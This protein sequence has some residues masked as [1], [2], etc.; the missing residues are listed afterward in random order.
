MRG[1][2]Y[3]FGFLLAALLVGCTQSTLYNQIADES[4]GSVFRQYKELSSDDVTC[5]VMDNNHQLWIG[6]SYGLN[7]YDGNVFTQFYT[8]SSDSL[9]IPNNQV[10]TLFK[11]SRGRIWIGTANGLALYVGYGRFKQFHFNRDNTIF[12]VTQIIETSDGRLFASSDYLIYQ[13]VPEAGFMRPVEPIQASKEMIR[14]CADQKGG[15]WVNKPLSSYYYDKQYRLVDSIVQ[16]TRFSNI[17]RLYRDV[18]NNE[19][20]LSQGRVLSCVDLETRKVKFSTETE[21]PI[22]P[23]L[24]YKDAN[25]LY[26]KSD[27]HGLYSFQC[28]THRL[29]FIDDDQVPTIKHNIL[30]S[31]LYKDDDQNLWIGYKNGGYQAISSACSD[32]ILLNKQPLFR[33]TAGHHI[34]TLA[35]DDHLIWGSTESNIFCYDLRDKTFELFPQEDVLIDTPYYRQTLKKILPLSGLLWLLTDVRAILVQKQGKSL[36]VL[37]VYRRGSMNDICSDGTD[38]Y[39][40]SHDG[41]NVDYIYYLHQD[42]LVDS[43]R[44][45][46]PS[47]DNQS[48]LF[49]LGGDELLLYMVGLKFA[50]LNTATKQMRNL[51]VKGVSVNPEMIPTCLVREGNSVWLGTKSHGLFR[52]DLAANALEAVPELEG[53]Q[54]MSLIQDKKGTLWMG[55]RSGVAIYRPQTKEATI[56]YTTA[57][58]NPQFNNFSQGCICQ[59]NGTI[60][61]GGFMGC[62][63]LPEAV[64]SHVIRSRLKIND[65]FIRSKDNRQIVY[66]KADS[67]S[68]Q[69]RY[70]QN[71]LDISFSGSIFDKSTAY[72]YR[73]RL[74]NFDNNWNTAHQETMAG[75]SNLPAGR[76][77]FRVQV[78]QI[79]GNTVIE[80]ASISI[81]I[82]KAPWL[83]APAMLAYLALLLGLIFYIN[84]L[85]LRLHAN[86]LALEMARKDKEREEKVNQMNMS[87][88]ANISHEFRNPLTIIAGP[89]AALNSDTGLPRQAHQKIRIV[90]QS[91]NRMLRLI[92]Q[93]LD[94]NQLETDALK[95]K[96]AEY[97]ICHEISQ[98]VDPFRES[99]NQRRVSFCCEGLDQPCYTWL[100]QDKL[101]KILS[102][103]YT[104]ALKHTPD[105]G[106]IRLTFSETTADEARSLFDESLP[107]PDY[108]KVELFN[109]GKQIPGDKLENVFKR[110][111]Q[112][113]DTLENHTYGWG[114]GIGLYYVKRLVTLH[115]GAISVRNVPGEGVV[116]CFVL[117]KGEAPYA[118]FER[119]TQKSPSILLLPEEKADLPDMPAVVKNRQDVNEMLQKPRLLIVDDDIQIGQYLHLLFE[120]RFVIVNKY[121]AESA[122]AEISQIDPDIIISDVIMNEMSGYEFCHL[123][124][125]DVL[126]SHIPFILLTA[127]SNVD[128][129]VEGLEQGA[130]AYVTKPFDPRYLQALVSSLLKNV[131]RIR[132]QLNTL[133]ETGHLSN[134]LSQQDRRFMDD[135]YHSMEKHITDL[136]L[137]IPTICEEMAMSRTKLNY[138]LKGLTGTT[139]GNFFKKYKLN[140]AASLLKEGKLNISEIALNTG[141]GTVAYFSSSFKK[142]FGIS[143]SKYK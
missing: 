2:G 16:P 19:M 131:E 4:R 60:F 35:K 135:L 101:D 123:L 56:K 94:F 99:A 124:K 62:A 111:Y 7:L 86:K 1:F 59:V 20:W 74:D 41:K 119:L 110:Y 112:V 21:M 92:D 122:L 49:H 136:D 51:D 48:R 33:Q 138:K 104:N 134:D 37:R 50:V 139:P 58:L 118:G 67:N 22:L 103:L 120:N 116:F 85:Y 77:R 132:E 117:P 63:A 29:Q 72:S 125:S 10:T 43:V 14:I 98:M 100:D 88:F 23:L 5:F 32:N 137:N 8:N 78:V 9:S 39:F 130:N 93:M 89:M 30:I 26:L 75:Y 142:E 107:Y 115:K 66:Q 13:I 44:V 6:T 71:D 133:T 47:F 76:Y 91:V 109:N 84:R 73:Y 46:H 113:K 127:K 40:N 34:T 17:V 31:C 11:D 80:E 87:F 55:T 96:V 121:S 38:C 129:S 90:C 114:T 25:R 28:D 57:Y 36:K 65:V 42:R 106:T 140:R 18:K 24:I 128:E 126:Y 64:S 52:L 45:T 83:S 12:P 68:Y 143:P 141:F 61:L 27:K 82:S 102:N 108:V 69:F 105:E 3:L 97:D 81:G 54:V 15:I 79:P 95:L 53:I 70:N